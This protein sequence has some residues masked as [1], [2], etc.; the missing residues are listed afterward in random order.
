[1][2]LWRHWPE[3][4]EKMSSKTDK[5]DEFA[6]IEALAKHVAEAPE[7]LGLNDDGAALWFGDG[8]KL[9][10][11]ADM[12]QAGVH[13]LSNA[14]PDQVICKALRTNLSDIAAMGAAPAFFLCTLAL[15]KK[16]EAAQIQQIVSALDKEQKHFGVSLIGGDTIGGKGPFTVSI[17]VLGWAA[18][19]LLR[20]SG[21]K[22]GDD[23]WVSGHIGDGWL[24]LQVAQQKITSLS[25]AHEKS[26]LRRYEYPEP[27][28]KLGVA[29]AGI[30]HSAIDVSDGLLG[31]A[32]HIA[33]ASG[34]ALTIRPALVP[35][36]VATQNWLRDENDPETSRV[37]LLTG[38]DDYELLFTAP[39]ENVDKI[40]GLSAALGINLCRIG[41]VCA[42]EGVLL[43]NEAGQRHTAPKTGFTHF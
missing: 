21:A 23:V 34:C 17:T 28:L 38:G 19:P 31:D 2:R 20:R 26:V 14:S 18:G 10:V 30:A 43:E 29:L 8:R 33:N 3:I 12:L 11:V 32:V 5:I 24:G 4:S 15:P 39:T 35:L 1:M 25:S 13:T 6:F 27:R 42:G 36:S 40:T 16:P 22:I 7:A 41:K 37:S 9:V